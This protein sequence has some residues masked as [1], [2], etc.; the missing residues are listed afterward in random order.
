LGYQHSI[1]NFFL[2]PIGMFYGCNFSVGKFIYQSIIPVTLGN[3]FGATILGALPF[4]YL[5]GRNEQA[6]D[7]TTGQ[8]LAVERASDRRA[9]QMEEGKA[10]QDE[11]RRP[12]EE[13]QSKGTWLQRMR[14]GK[15]ENFWHGGIGMTHDYPHLA[16]PNRRSGGSDS[17]AVDG[18]HAGTSDHNLGETSHTAEAYGGREDT[19]G[20]VDA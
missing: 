1:A 8:P 9:V 20:M 16:S 13:Q 12:E 11:Q 4:W 7:L 18:R 15:S 5:Y 19:R 2:V 3:I 10:E 6:L 17:T 14:S